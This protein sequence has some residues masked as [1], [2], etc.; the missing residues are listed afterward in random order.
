MPGER[1]VFDPLLA[2]IL[3]QRKRE[4]VC[5][6]AAKLV[7]ARALAAFRSFAAR[8]L[9]RDS[10]GSRHCIVAPDVELSTDDIERAV[11]LICHHSAQRVC[12]RPDQGPST[13]LWKS[14]APIH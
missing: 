14:S 5:A 12:P 11:G 9:E 7:D 10:I 2:A 4:G 8:F 1:H 3:D 13:S 6:G